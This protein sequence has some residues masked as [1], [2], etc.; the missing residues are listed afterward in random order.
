[1]KGF[2]S[3]LMRQV[4]VVLQVTEPGK[5]SETVIVTTTTCSNRNRRATSRAVAH[6]R[7]TRPEGTRV[8]RIASGET[9]QFDDLLDDDRGTRTTK[10]RMD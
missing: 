1:M 9:G 3:G 8:A 7:L 4:D 6:Q 5:P 2:F 10:E